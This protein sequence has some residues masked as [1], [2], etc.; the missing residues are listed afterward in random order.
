MTSNIHYSSESNEWGTPTELYDHYNKRF[1][2]TLD[3]CATKENH[4]CEKYYTKEDDGLK[5]DWSGE[6]V[7]MNP[8]Y[9]REIKHWIKKAYEESLM[10]AV[11]VCLIPARVDTKYWHDYIFDKA[12]IKFIKGRLRF[13]KDGVPRDAAPFPSAIVVYGDVLLPRELK[14]DLRV[15]IAE[16]I[17]REIDTMRMRVEM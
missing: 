17:A 6:V 5:Q 16:R 7:F 14:E 13:E 15:V 3:P 1:K 4:K 11:V 8:P 2:F 12:D 9:G 10:G